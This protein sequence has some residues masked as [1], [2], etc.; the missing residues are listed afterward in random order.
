MEGLTEHGLGLQSVLW[1]KELCRFSES[2]AIKSRGVQEGG[3][4][5]GGLILVARVGISPLEEQGLQQR[6][7]LPVLDADVQRRAPCERRRRARVNT[8][9]AR[10]H[11]T[12][13]HP[14]G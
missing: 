12:C 5:R 9:R 6:C 1:K 13:K 10:K 7:A 4:G 11:I 8:P 14:Q 3:A 2:A